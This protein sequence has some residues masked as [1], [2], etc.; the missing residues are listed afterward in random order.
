MCVCDDVL[1]ASLRLSSLRRLSGLVPYSRTWRSV[2]TD[3]NSSRV[4]FLPRILCRGSRNI[5]DSER[6]FS[7]ANMVSSLE[8]LKAGKFSDIFFQYNEG[9]R[10]EKE[11]NEASKKTKCV[12]EKPF[13]EQFF[14]ENFSVLT[15]CLLS[16]VFITYRLFINTYKAQFLHDRILHPQS[17]P[18]SKTNNY[19]TNY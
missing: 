10:I 15:S 8:L 1:P 5:K 12:I 17:Y 11:E 3:C 14:K 19:L 18:I 2:W 6:R 4:A 7:C 9:V 13:I 16:C